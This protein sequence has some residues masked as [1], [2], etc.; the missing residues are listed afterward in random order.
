MTNGW[1]DGVHRNETALKL[2]AEINEILVLD[3]ETRIKRFGTEWRTIVD[4][5]MD[6]MMLAQARGLHAD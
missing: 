5:F 2:R 4:M 3:E 6:Q 1:Y